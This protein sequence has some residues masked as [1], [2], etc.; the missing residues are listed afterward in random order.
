MNN[1]QSRFSKI[2]IGSIS[3]R[4]KLH[5]QIPHSIKREVRDPLLPKPKLQAV[6]APK[7]PEFKNF[8][9]NLFKVSSFALAGFIMVLILQSLTYLISA[10]KASG[11]ILG[12]ATS[13]YSDL[14]S[15][16]KNL[17]QQN[18]SEANSLF[19]T[20]SQ[21]VMQAQDKLNNFKAL[22]WITATANSADHI[23]RGASLLSAAGQKLTE[24]LSLLEELKIR[25]DEAAS[26]SLEDKLFRNKQLLTQTK[27]LILLSANEFEQ[28]SAI[29]ADYAQTLDQAKIQVLQL[30]SILDKLI[31]LEDLYLRIFGSNK[32]YLLIFQNY[33]EQRATGGFIG[34]F[35]VLKTN[36]G[37][38]SKLTIDSIYDLD[39]QIF[40]LVAAPGPFQPQ[41]KRWGARD[42]NW[43][44]DFP[45]SAE[46]LLYFF[47][48]GGQTADGV[49]SFTPK[50]FERLLALVGP[51]EMYDYG[52]MLTS[53]NFQEVVQ[54]KTSHD[55]DRELNE[56][57]KFLADF[58]P[59]LL[60]RLT[61]LPKDEWLNFFQ[62]MRDSL[63][64]R[65]ILLYNKD[66][67]TQKLIDDL[68]ASGKILSTDYDYLNIIN[69]N[70][71]GTKTD[72]EMEQNVTLKS[73]ILSDGSIL[74]TLFIDRKNNSNNF[75]KNYLRVLVPKAS[76][77][78]S[79]GGFD[80]L[81]HYA[82]VARGLRTDPDLEAWD[83][84][85]LNSNVFVRTE[86]GK[87]EFAGWVVTEA[88]EVQKLTL[89]YLLPFKVGSIYSLLLQKQAG[90]KPYNFQGS[91]S[92]GQFSDR[93]ISE[94][95]SKS[96]NSL[97]FA[98][99][100]NTD[101]FWGTVISK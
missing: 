98:S 51:I 57:K 37:Q 58:A 2:D 93:W 15:A 12:A 81:P 62:I 90:S 47:E 83:L 55:Y 39:G 70:L 69:S 10:K 60:D 16:G 13:A 72:L 9:K 80:D 74:N 36:H 34:T 84:G 5:K 48:K 82:S 87:T 43:F 100:A 75:N 4:R 52:A 76:Q 6:L 77:L 14:N 18:F 49:I 63:D 59:I 92:L 8:G 66:E 94:G 7:K 31:D 71:G 79:T 54:Y 22:T 88:F 44:A 32:T 21:N 28:V 40:E 56:P 67:S 41:I 3:R 30:G 11:E 19:I 50:V 86:S 45:T 64:Q 73:K 38:I 46:K 23:L 95:V 99:Y 26:Q 24:A 96:D 20:A 53:E 29:P 25:S 68:G 97:D 91:L 1:M 42:A 17:G 78:V 65:H 101:D 61:V 85:E 27:E 89:T 35:G 33:D